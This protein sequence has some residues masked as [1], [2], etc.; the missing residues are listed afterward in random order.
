[1]TSTNHSPGSVL[2]TGANRGIGLGLA[3]SFAGD[4]WQVSACCRQPDDAVDLQAL[5]S[6]HP[7]QIQIETLD[8]SDFG[9][10]DAL[11]ARLADQPLDVLINNA[12]TIGPRDPDN[13]QLHRQFFGSLDYTAWLEVLRVNA[14]APVKMAEAFRPQL[15]AGDA[16][17]IVNLSSTIGSIEEEAI[18][19]F[20]YATSKTT[21][22]KSMRLVASQL[23]DAGIAVGLFCPG[24]VKTDLGGP[25]ASV[26]VADSVAGLRRRIDELNL[27]N[28]GDFRR[29]NGET[30]AW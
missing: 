5:Q 2:I 16:K 8:V 30:I 25:G 9:Q 19:V 17:K 15:M 21:L 6:Q 27:H 20:A 1:M 12:A 11:A 18:P 23:R 13:Q 10:I 24:H 29:Y 14:F 28:S 26:E 3:Q 7:G 22:N 4:G